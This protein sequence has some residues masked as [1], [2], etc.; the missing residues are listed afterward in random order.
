MTARRATEIALGAAMATESTSAG[1]SSAITFCAPAWSF[2]S[3]SACAFSASF[4]YSGLCTTFT[5]QV[6]WVSRAFS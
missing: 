6:P 2:R 4:R 5:K 1:C 3:M